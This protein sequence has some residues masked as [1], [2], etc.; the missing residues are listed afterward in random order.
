MIKTETL[1]LIGSSLGYVI[2]AITLIT[3]I[4]K[5]FRA[6]ASGFIKKESKADAYEQR[7][8]NL[9]NLLNQQ[10]KEDKEFKEKIYALISHQSHADRQLLANIIETTYYQN[11]DTKTLDSIALKRITNAYAI[12]HDEFN[13]NSYISAIY[14]EMIE[15]WEH[16]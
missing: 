5:H 13:G 15:D 14:T 7:L 4:V 12:Y 11:K 8:Q 2:S 10:I 6:K 3:M 9:E 1:M 16:I